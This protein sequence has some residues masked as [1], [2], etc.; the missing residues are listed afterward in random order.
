MVSESLN[1]KD[2]DPEETQEWLDALNSVLAFDGQ[3]RVTFILQKLLQQANA[4]GIRLGTSIHTPY[5]NTISALKEKKIPP[6]HGMAK[7][8]SA[9][10]RWNAVAM[11][12]RA[13]KKAP[14]LG[15]HIASYASAATLYEVG[16]N[17]FFKGP[18]QNGGDLLYIQGHS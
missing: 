7:R 8:I 18:E 6:D 15:G 9:L 14:E 3:E 17:H 5:C 11:V 16:F 10:I 2:I 1:N 12:L 4:E 13:V